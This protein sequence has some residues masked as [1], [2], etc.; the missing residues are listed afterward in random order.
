MLTTGAGIG[1]CEPRNF[2]IDSSGRWLMATTQKW[3]SLVAFRI[4]PKTGI[5]VPIGSPLIV[6]E[7]VC[8]LFAARWRRDL[9]LVKV[10]RPET[11]P[12][13]AGALTRRL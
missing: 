6:P 1:S 2:A 11:T 5:P 8:V 7:P 12:A 3:N 13:P 9:E 4:D 10:G